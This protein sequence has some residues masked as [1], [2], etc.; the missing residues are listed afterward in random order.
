VYAQGL[1]LEA[2]VG[3]RGF[4]GGLGR[5]AKPGLWASV[6]SGYE[7][8]PWLMIALGVE[9]SMHT[10]DAPSPPSAISFERID[11]VLAPRMQLAFS[12]RTA[13]FIGPELAAGFSPGD[14]L[15][16]YGFDRANELGFGFGGSLGV[17]W[18]LANR[19]HS[20]GLL[21]GARLEPSLVGTS[22][23]A[24]LAIHSAAYLK[25]VF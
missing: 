22:G 21:A 19:H 18:H 17:D 4:A 25:Y 10:M 1:Y 12:D 7:L 24:T 15:R 3:G 16:V 5:Y 6:L 14:M 2:V 23:E 8:T 11:A 9:L 20:L 13:M